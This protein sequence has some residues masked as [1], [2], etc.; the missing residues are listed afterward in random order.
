MFLRELGW[1]WF[2]VLTG[3]ALSMAHV[4]T[5]HGLPVMLLP[6]LV[7]RLMV[8]PRLVAHVTVLD[9]ALWLMVLLSLDLWL[10]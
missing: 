9:L 5:C 7:L 8:F 4:A 3:L 6:D 1:W 2:M 10:M